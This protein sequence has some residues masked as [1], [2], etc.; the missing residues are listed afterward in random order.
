MTSSPLKSPSVL[1][2]KINKAR[3]QCNQR[4]QVLKQQA[5]HKRKVYTAAELQNKND[6]IYKLSE[7]V[8]ILGEMFEEQNK[9]ISRKVANVNDV[10]NQLK[11]KRSGILIRNDDDDQFDGFHDIQE[12]DDSR[13][14]NE[15]EKELL[16]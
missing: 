14:L 8:R 3:K 13:E 15:F 5:R 11:S 2:E 9:E 1:K 10:E 7:N 4:I 16:E 6:W 12:K